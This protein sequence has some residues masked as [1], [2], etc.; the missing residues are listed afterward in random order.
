MAWGEDANKWEEGEGGEGGAV[1]LLGDSEVQAN[2]ALLESLNAGDR[3]KLTLS[4]AILG[5]LFGCTMF[6]I[7]FIIII[8]SVH[9]T[10]HHDL[11]QKLLQLFIR[12]R[13]ATL[14]KKLYLHPC[15]ELTSFEGMRKFIHEKVNSTEKK[16]IFF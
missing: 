1:A 11:S 2:A 7:A 3:P 10:I 15:L 5:A 8:R 12:A 13:K 14:H 4:N 6:F 16:Y 9:S